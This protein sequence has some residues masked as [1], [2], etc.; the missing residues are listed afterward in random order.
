MYFDNEDSRKRIAD[1]G[2]RGFIGGQ[3]P[4]MW[5]GIGTLQYHFL[6]SQGLRPSSK[7]L[8]IACGSLR[9]GQ[10]L[11]PYL[12]KG[13]Y[14]GLD[15]EPRLIEAGLAHELPNEIVAMKAPVFATNTVFDFSFIESFDFAMAQSLFTHLVMQD[16]DLCFRHLRG[17][18]HN[19]S[20]F[21]FTFF[22][23]DSSN[24]RHDVSHANRRWMYSRQEL[25][26]T[27][28]QRGWKLDYIGAWNHPR[29][30]MMMLATP[31]NG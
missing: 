19:D 14:F 26:D 13:N 7:F 27:A 9:L 24:N 15:A 12:D 10:Y 11:I 29:Q 1:M 6:I 5:Y 25:A 22:E 30:Q 21:Y 20:R 16:I 17:K 3:T 23:G 28:G 18:A 31:A 8:D 4:E 2:H